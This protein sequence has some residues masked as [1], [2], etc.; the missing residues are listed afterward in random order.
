[1]ADFKPAA[2]TFSATNALLLAQLCNA[3]YLDQGAAGTATEALGLP[4]FVWIDLTEHFT[5]LYAM[6][7]GGP[8]FFVIAFRGT[9]NFED[10][11]TDLQATPVSFPWIFTGCPDI[12]DIHAGFGHALV[13][14]WDQ[15]RKAIGD[16][17]P[18]PDVAPDRQIS[19]KLI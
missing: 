17:V 14:A 6:A 8:E 2:T 18:R 19:R 16:L 9:K 15:I 10:W 3:A 5:D 1:M 7:T 11:M 13:D 12:G 4:G